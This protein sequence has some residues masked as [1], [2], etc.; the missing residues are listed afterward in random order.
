MTTKSIIIKISKRLFNIK[1]FKQ[2]VAPQ[3]PIVPQQPVAVQNVNPV[4]PVVPEIPVAPAAPAV[5]QN[6]NS[7]WENAPR[8]PPP[9]NV[10][11]EGMI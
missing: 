8:V 3:Q 7:G 4:A 6:S 5:P 1:I 10:V 2:V 9:S 11:N